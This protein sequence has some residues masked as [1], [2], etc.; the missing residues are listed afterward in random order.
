MYVLFALEVQ[1]RVVHI[2]GVTAHLAGAWTARQA[3]NLLM[4]L[5]ERASGFRF[6][7][8][9]RDGKFTAAS[10]SVFSGN[11]TRVIKTPVRSPRASSYAERFAGDAAPR[12]PG[13]RADPRRA[14]SPQ[15]SG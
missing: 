13:P 1:T 6:L 12:V 3:R 15:R 10:G 9:D 7:V 4:E 11:G 14:A 5:G 8:R 2:L